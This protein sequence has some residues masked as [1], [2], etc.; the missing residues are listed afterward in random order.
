[1]W[2]V[3]GL[4]LKGVRCSP[5]DQAGCGSGRDDLKSRALRKKDLSVERAEL[6][7]VFSVN[8]HFIFELLSLGRHAFT[9]VEQ[10]EG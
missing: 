10:H 1:M 9:V 5:G 8:I 3:K 6:G 2:R 7:K 4:P